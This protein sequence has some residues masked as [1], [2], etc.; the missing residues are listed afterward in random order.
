MTEIPDWMPMEQ[1]DGFIQMRLKKCKKDTTDR[2]KRHFIKLLTVWRDMGFN[3]EKIINNSI[4]GKWK[5]LYLPESMAPTK[6]HLKP[7]NKVQD[8][9]DRM[10]TIKTVPPAV[11]VEESRRKLRAQLVKMKEKEKCLKM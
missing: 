8:L 7:A 2:S 9:V 6:R 5:D 11:D 4:E 1:W 3:I 10:M